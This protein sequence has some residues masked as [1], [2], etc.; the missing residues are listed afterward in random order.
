MKSYLLYLLPFLIVI[1]IGKVFSQEKD[2]QITQTK[3]FTVYHA[4]DG[5]NIVLNLKA[6]YYSKGDT[7]T[8]FKDDQR[9]FGLSSP[10]NLRE[11][12]D[13][14]THSLNNTSFTNEFFSEY[15]LNEIFLWLYLFRVDD[16]EPNIG[17]LNLGTLT[18]HDENNSSARVFLLDSMRNIINHQRAVFSNNKK[19]VVSLLN[20]YKS[21]IGDSNKESSD[22]VLINNFLQRFH[23][24]PFPELDTVALY[25]I[26]QK[27]KKTS[28]ENNLLKV[29]G[30]AY[31]AARKNVSHTNDVLRVMNI[32][33]IEKVSI[34]FERG[35]IERIQAWVRNRTGGTDIYENTFAI[36]F[37][38]INNLK[39]FQ[40][41]KLFM[42]KSSKIGFNSCI[43]LSDVIG[44]YDNLLDLYTRDY[45]PADTV[46]NF[47]Y[48]EEMPL[49]SLKKERN[50]R[51][52]DGKIFT[53]LG[54]IDQESP[55]GLVQVEICRRFNLNTY[56]WQAGERQD[57]GAFSY[58]NVYGALSKIEDKNKVL[59]LHNQNTVINNTLV[60]PS[61]TTNLDLRRYE[62]FSMGVDLNALLYDFPDMKFTA[63]LDFG[64][65]YGHVV[66]GDTIRN[67][68]GGIVAPGKDTSFSGHTVTL[69]LPKVS[70][71]IFQERRV[72]LVMSYNY[73]HTYA[74][75]NNQF[76][77]IMS[78]KKSDLNNIVTERA[79]RNSHQL[80]LLLR[81]ETSEK[82]NGQIFFRSRF[83]WQQGDA[84]TF[85]SQIQV[86]Y[87]YNIIYRNN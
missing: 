22:K 50:I 64:I 59:P 29:N 80:E 13:S 62:N 60:S 48:P 3:K 39:A 85:F 19:A 4:N 21:K 27:N 42:R 58:L 16:K 11:F 74:F 30:P 49:I 26:G 36:G 17:F 51:L 40:R 63:Y 76:K 38:S 5:G 82:N 14:I 47:A 6:T 70:I 78:Y 86:G 12:R 1:P 18:N 75:T 25:T 77:Q 15:S 55:N 35:Y 71:E 53:D 8:V 2:I 37:S 43:F 41:T 45:S 28:P 79:A 81:V 73:N 68:V 7:F 67:I 83:F 69:M 33:P 84:N 46:I 56:R 32:F 54:G 52:F 61:Y 65:R 24:E 87:A 34:Q 23:D 72:G 20:Q 57:V 66:L 44:N 9:V 31:E 10:L